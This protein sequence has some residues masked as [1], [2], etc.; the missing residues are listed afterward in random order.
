MT[1]A[2]PVATARFHAWA[3]GTRS[4]TTTMSMTERASTSGWPSW[5]RPAGRATIR[6]S[7]PM[8]AMGAEG[9][10]ASNESSAARR[11][12]SAGAAGSLTIG[13]SSDVYEP[14]TRLSRMPYHR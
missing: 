1:S 8:V 9:L 5:T 14:L 2:A 13:L 6:P 3:T 4:S 7:A 10:D 12:R 11:T